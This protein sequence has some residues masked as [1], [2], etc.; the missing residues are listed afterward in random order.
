[1]HASALNLRAKVSQ[2]IITKQNVSAAPADTHSDK[3]C[4][5]YV[6]MWLY[7]LM[8]CVVVWSISCST[9]ARS[10]TLRIVL[11]H[12]SRLFSD[13]HLFLTV[14]QTHSTTCVDH[15]NN[16][17][18]PAP[19][20]PEEI[21][22]LAARFDSNAPLSQ[23][24]HFILKHLASSYGSTTYTPWW[25]AAPSASIDVSVDA[26]PTLA[27]QHTIHDS[28]LA[29]AE[30][31][32]LSNHFSSSTTPTSLQYQVFALLVGYS[33]ALR[34]S[35]GLWNDPISCIDTLLSSCSILD[36]AYKPYSLSSAINHWCTTCTCPTLTSRSPRAIAA[37]LVDVK[38]LLM[39]NT[40][41]C[42]ALLDCWLLACA[43]VGYVTP[44]AVHS[45]SNGN[46]PLSSVLLPL[47]REYDGVF[48]S[49]V[50]KNVL[51]SELLARK[52]YFIMSACF[53]CSDVSWRTS[54]ALEVEVYCEEY[55]TG[56]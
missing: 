47:L 27:T 51:P 43:D 23:C 4:S 41:C 16:R 2:R 12:V 19:P 36:V 7:E 29:T 20:R 35:C 3:L 46:L 14:H 21:A 10:A 33:I 44:E 15:F 28:A 42:A 32:Q 26:I 49:R 52:V 53:S 18:S 11:H 9:S 54:L 30:L 48:K 56:T 39:S 22:G 5:V 50:K 8:V 31:S 24:D 37:V 1:M 25:E 13:I 17:T 34:S 55:L 45:V 6:F 40:F 38:T